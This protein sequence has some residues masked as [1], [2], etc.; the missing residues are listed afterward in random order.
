MTLMTRCSGVGGKVRVRGGAVDNFLKS[1][2]QNFVKLYTFFELVI[3]GPPF[4]HSQSPS[5]PSKH[6][7]SR[8]L[9]SIF[10]IQNKKRRIKWFTV[11]LTAGARPVQLLQIKALQLHIDEATCLLG[12]THD[13]V[14]YG[15]FGS[16]EY[17]R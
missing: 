5:L 7:T 13:L 16:N 2:T 4:L 15:A 6:H 1:S 10:L 17:K 9:Q 8:N 11:D 3:L 14:G 12:L